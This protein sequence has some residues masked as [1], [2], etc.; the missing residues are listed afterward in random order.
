VE[1]TARVHA[2]PVAADSRLSELGLTQA[3]LRRTIQV[4]LHYYF[5]VTRHDPV[6]AGGSLMWIKC[7]RGLRDRLVPRGWQ[8]DNTHN[9]PTTVHPTRNDAIAVAAGNA[10]TG[11]AEIDPS[12]K[13]D[14]G[15]ATRGAVDTNRQLS[16][17]D[18]LPVAE[19]PLIVQPVT[20]PRVRTWVLLHF[21]DKTKEEV[22]VELSLPTYMTGEG[23]VRDWQE[24][25]N[26]TPI[27]FR[28]DPLPLDHSSEPDIEIDITRK[29][30]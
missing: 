6:G 30:N 15:P 4:G 8:A 17:F 26:L 23:F 10:Y 18:L 7:V 12:T 14:R 3:D 29:A 22:R 11:I 16:L 2:T 28:R 13:R 25:I 24:R 1:S 21:I 27:P 19:I 9:Y 20:S 5:D